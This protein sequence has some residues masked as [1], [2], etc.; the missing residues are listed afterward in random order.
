MTN[1]SFFIK[2]INNFKSFNKLLKCANY[3]FIDEINC[4][5]FKKISK[6]TKSKPIFDK[7]KDDFELVNSL[8]DKQDLLNAATVLRTLY[9]NIIYIIVTSYNK[10][11]KITLDTLPGELRKVLVE[12][13]SSLFSSYFEPEDFNDIYKYLCKIIHPCSLK[14][15][16]SYLNETTK[17]KN[18]LLGNLKYM[19]LVIEYMYLNF[20]NKRINNDESKFDLNF[21]DLCTYVNLM[22]IAYYF[23]DAKRDKN[24]IKRYF[25]YDTN[26]KYV[27]DNQEKIKA[28]YGTL[29]DKKDLVE[30]DIKELTKELTNQINESKYKAAIIGLL[31]GK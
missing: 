3:V 10:E 7:V 21:I 26:N 12:N 23:D 11:I 18:Y 5:E 15:L 13:C 19:V 9:E 17:Y 14:E 16:V 2:K 28:V 24:F 6:Y 25:Y 31:N 27:N 22:N 8:I 30:K 20:L 29:T 4:F 1:N